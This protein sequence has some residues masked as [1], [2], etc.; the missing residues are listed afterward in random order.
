VTPPVLGV[1]LPGAPPRA[2]SGGF[3]ETLALFS[4]T[5]IAGFVLAAR[6]RRRR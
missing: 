1:R 3:D 5:L 6:W 2:G 4:S